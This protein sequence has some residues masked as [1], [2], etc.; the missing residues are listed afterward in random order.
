[1]IVGI[2]R[3]SR[4]EESLVAATPTTVA[5]LLELGYEV[6]VQAGAGVLA[7][8]ADLAFADAGARVATIDGARSGRPTRSSG[9]TKTSSAAAAS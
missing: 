8:Q 2:P 7:D 1:M 6:M 9:S 5:Q 4:A 3:E